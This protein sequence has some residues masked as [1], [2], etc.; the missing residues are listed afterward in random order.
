MDRRVGRLALGSGLT[1]LAIALAVVMSA[2]PAASWSPW[3]SVG[4]GSVSGG[5]AS[6]GRANGNLDVVARIGNTI[7]HGFWSSSAGWT[8]FGSTRCKTVAGV[9]VVARLGRSPPATLPY[10]PAVRPLRPEVLA[11]SA[12][13]PVSHLR[14]SK[15][16][17][18]SV[19]ADV[20]GTRLQDRLPD[21]SREIT[22]PACRGRALG[23]A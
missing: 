1:A 21:F 16:C 9:A 15:G 5:L 12:P 13:D 20:A 22:R 18:V 19:R 17:S 8:K 10:F 14:S 3:G 2:L 6:A 4:G 23:I 11:R 7:Y